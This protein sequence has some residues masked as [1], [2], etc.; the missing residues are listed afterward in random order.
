MRKSLFMAF[1]L[2]AAISMGA[3]AM[4]S[5]TVKVPP[6]PVY[7]STSPIPITVGLVVNEAPGVQS[8]GRA[9]TNSPYGPLI[10]AEL[11]KL[12]VFRGIVYP[13]EKGAAADAVLR[14]D[15]KGKWEYFN[16][17]R[18]PYDAW[19]GASTV[20]YAEG[21][22][23]VTVVMT[24]AGRR[25]INDSIPVKSRSEYFGQDYDLIARMLN[26]AQAKRIAVT[27]A[28]FLQ[29]KQ[30]HIMAETQMQPHAQ[31]EKTGKTPPS[32]GAAV[33]GARPMGN[34]GRPE[35]SAAG[36]KKLRELENLH[37][38]GVLSD[39]DFDRAKNR[40]D[41]MR[42]LEDLYKSGV[43]TEKEYKRAMGRVSGR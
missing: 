18:Q 3:C 5:T 31:G 9:K 2:L 39:Q 41:Q 27:L 36:E 38:S 14:L 35:T 32:G 4:A 26:R 21:A 25:I 42:K 37:A 29:G 19:S 33:S 1:F 20:H 24:M 13:Y 6:A 30:D 11:E 12:Q 15:I 23:D 34:A 10:A 16:K 40:L 7:E 43:L 22:H 28:S 17:G 8:Q